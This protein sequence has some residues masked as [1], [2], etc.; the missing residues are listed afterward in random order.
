MCK[1]QATI[2]QREQS[3][4]SEWAAVLRTHVAHG[5]LPNAFITFRSPVNAQQKCELQIGLQGDHLLYI[6]I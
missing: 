2:T 5:L 3:V 6:K 1:L 4:G